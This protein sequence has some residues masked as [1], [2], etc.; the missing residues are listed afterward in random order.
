MFQTLTLSWLPLFW[1]IELLKVEPFDIY[2]FKYISNDPKYLQTSM[3][4]MLKVF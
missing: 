2:A 1:I 3:W 4:K